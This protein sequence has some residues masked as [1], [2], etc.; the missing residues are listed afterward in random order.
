MLCIARNEK[1]RFVYLTETAQD[2][3]KC[4]IQ[5]EEI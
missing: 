2:N 1:F 3:I 5:Y 4:Q